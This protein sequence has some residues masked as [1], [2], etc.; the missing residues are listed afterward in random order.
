IRAAFDR[1]AL[2]AL[3]KRPA[4]RFADAASFARALANASHNRTRLARGTH[5]A[6]VGD[7][8]RRAIR[9]AL[10]DGDVA[11]IAEGYTQLA[12]APLRTQRV[13]E[14]IRELREGT[15][16]V[17]RGHGPSAPDAPAAVHRLV[18]ELHAL[19]APLLTTERTG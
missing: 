1:I 7:E 2:E 12:R 6:E 3:D 14:A 11:K 10:L 4:A 15:A 8:H 9:Q 18:A 13:G 19:H 17:T 16:V 5:P